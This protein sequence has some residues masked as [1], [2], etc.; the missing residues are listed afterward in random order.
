MRTNA[1]SG[2]LFA[3]VCVRLRP[4]CLKMERRLDIE[5]LV[6]RINARH[7]TQFR[8]QGRYAAGENEGAFAIVDAH[9]VAYVLKWNQRPAWVQSI[10]R[11][12]RI[13]DHLRSQHV[14]VPAYTLADTFEGVAY[15]IQTALPGAPPP[16]LSLAQL[17]QL[18]VY[19]DVQ[20][21]QSITPEQNWS[22]YVLAVVFRGESGWSNSLLNDG[23]ATRAVLK[24]L[25]QLLADKHSMVLRSDDIVHGDLSLDNVLVAG[26]R[27]SGI[28]DWDA[29]GCG[30]R[31][32]DLSKLLFYSYKQPALREPLSA[33]IRALSG[34]AGLALYLG[35]NILAQ[36]DWS[37]RHHTP[38]AIAEVAAKSHRILHDLE[39]QEA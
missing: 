28:V 15:W 6:T 25:T 10:D 16:Q 19:I 31:C 3:F 11:A 4:V 33:R 23:P 24:R 34:Q 27:V 9:N 13:T 17:Q 14:P 30:D 18:L 21:G 1:E 32:L 7:E 2:Q 12:R 29:A 35:Y 20:A 39:A 37:I 5:Q 22:A 26:D 38:A 8:L 36:L